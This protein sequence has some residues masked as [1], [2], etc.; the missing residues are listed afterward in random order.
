MLQSEHGVD[1]R[2]IL[3]PSESITSDTDLQQQI[4][5]TTPA[6]IS[7]SDQS[8]AL[9]AVVAGNFLTDE[10][11]RATAVPVSVASVPSHA[12]TNAG[13]F[14]TQ[15]DGTALTALQ[16]IDDIV[17]GV[18]ANISKIAGVVPLMHSDGEL[19]VISQDYLQALAE[20]D[21]ANH[22]RW[23]KMGYNDGL[24]TSEE[25]MWTYS[26]QYVFPTAGSQVRIVSSDNTQDK[27]GGT[28]AL[29]VRVGYLKSDFTEGSVTLTLNGTANVDS[30]VSH[31]DIFRVNS[32]RVMTTGTNNAP[33]GNLTL[34]Q[35]T[36]GLVVGYIRL[37]K[38]RARSAIYTVP[39][40]KTLYIT[41]IAF[42]AAGT[43]YVIFTNH[44]NYDSVT[45]ALLPRGL[46]YPFSEVVLLNSAYTKSLLVPTR[47]PATTDLKVSVIAEAAGS[48][49][50]CHLRGW[51]E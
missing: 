24:A 19:R 38:T 27:A 6:N 2:H 21:I 34:T 36:G 7:E 8:M 51:L 30:G 40:G 43:K 26:S 16:K 49:A 20:G 3:E 23:D 13:T 29:T 14:A 4:A 15:V 5:R 17:D 1:G 31:A 22:T 39:L 42:S 12:V 44:A 45:S 18:G 11:L 32:F 41:S 10:Q 9:P 47:L 35:V 33:V 46:F 37:G 50:T 48:V 28:G 25:T